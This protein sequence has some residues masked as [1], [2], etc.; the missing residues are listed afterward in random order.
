MTPVRWSPEAVSDLE[1]IRDFIE[2]DSPYYAQLVV[3]RLVEA[4]DRLSMFPMSGR[5]VPE[6]S[7]PDLREIIVGSHRIVYRLHRDA[8]EIL[9]IFRGSRL[10]PLSAK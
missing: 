10:F 5:L 6:V 1:S 3:L 4:V 9:T 2:R 7:Q 8:V